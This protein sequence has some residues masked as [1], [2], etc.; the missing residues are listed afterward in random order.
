MYSGKIAVPPGGGGI[1]V[2]YVDNFYSWIIIV[3]YVIRSKN[4]VL[5]AKAGS[6][7]TE[8]SAFDRLSFPSG[9]I[10]IPRSTTV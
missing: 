7:A 8:L 1:V 9:L 6:F 5:R 10:R 4:E 2:H 3:Y